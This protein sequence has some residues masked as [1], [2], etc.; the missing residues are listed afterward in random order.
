VSRFLLI[1]VFFEVGIVL[2]VAP[3]T[4]HWERNYFAE[5]L[6]IVQAIIDNAFVR[7]AV[8][9]LGL[10]NLYSGF[11]ELVSLIMANRAPDPPTLVAPRETHEER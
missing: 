10:V 11:A 9:G 2:L 4:R 1:A 8:S 3:W 5:A 7:G 6:P